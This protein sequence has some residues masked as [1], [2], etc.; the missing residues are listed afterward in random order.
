MA[1]ANT[2]THKDLSLSRVPK[3]LVHHIEKDAKRERL[4]HSDV[5]RRILMRYY[6]MLNGN[7][8]AR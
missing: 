3:E 4:S 8:P 6:G 2:K 1:P 5:I 7:H